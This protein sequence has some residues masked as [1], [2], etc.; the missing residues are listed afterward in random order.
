MTR[1]SWPRRN[2]L[3]KCFSR[4]FFEALGSFICSKGLKGDTISA[5][6]KAFCLI[7]KGIRAA[8]PQPWRLGEA[9]LCEVLED[10]H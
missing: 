5:S 3:A 4:A 6:G 9:Y 8:A 7:Q 1:L 10:M 2:N